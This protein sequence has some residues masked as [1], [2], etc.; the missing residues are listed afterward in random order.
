M[1]TIE[2][3]DEKTNELIHIFDGTSEPTYVDEVLNFEYKDEE[4]A[5][6]VVTWCSKVISN[7]QIAFA[8]YVNLED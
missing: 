8:N 4:N 2:V 5:T 3:Y 7:K 6:F 1:V